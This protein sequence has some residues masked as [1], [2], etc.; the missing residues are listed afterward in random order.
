MQR[1][2]VTYSVFLPRAACLCHVQRVSATCSVFALRAAF[3]CHEQRLCVTYSVFL[4]RAA[5]LCHVQRV[6]VT[7]SVNLSRAARFCHG[8]ITSGASHLQMVVYKAA[9]TVVVNSLPDTGVTTLAT[10]V[11][12]SV[13]VSRG[14]AAKSS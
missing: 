6:C 14:S 13:R 9:V 5:C 2:C 7:Y 12:T 11:V 10:Q 8:C 1:V 4:P 3:L